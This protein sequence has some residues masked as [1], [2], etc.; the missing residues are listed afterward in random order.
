MTTGSF[1]VQ[2]AIDSRFGPVLAGKVTAGSL[3]V[4]MEAKSGTLHIEVAELRTPDG[5]HENILQAK[6]GDRLMIRPVEGIP[7]ATLKVLE[8]EVLE[9]RSEKRI[10]LR[11]KMALKPSVT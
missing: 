3:R 7:Q 6:R 4:G 11:S 5:D 9:F 2:E 8:K 10:P 1:L